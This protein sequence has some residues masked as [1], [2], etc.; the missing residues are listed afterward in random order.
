MS[1]RAKVVINGYGA[2]YKRGDKGIVDGYVSRDDG[3][4]CAVVICE[5]CNLAVVPVYLLKW[6]EW[7][8]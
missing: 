8:V 6:E 3:T 5:N 2:G 4:P 1:K 7:E